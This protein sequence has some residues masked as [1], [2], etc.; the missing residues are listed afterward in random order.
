MGGSRGDFSGVDWGNHERIA[1][2]NAGDETPEHQERVVRREPHQY[3]S[4]EEDCAG[5]HNRVPATDP[6]GGSSGEA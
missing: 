5:K 6:V 3:S 4:G 1:D 2:T